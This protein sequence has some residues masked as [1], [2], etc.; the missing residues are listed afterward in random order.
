MSVILFYLY[1]YDIKA[2][3]KLRDYSVQTPHIIDGWESRFSAS[4]TLVI[5]SFFKLWS[6]YSW[7]NLALI[8][9]LFFFLRWSLPLFPRLE[10]GG[11]ILAHCNLCLPGSSD[12]PASPSQ[13]A[14]TTGACHQAQLIFC[15]FSRDGF[16]H[17]GQAGLKLLYLSWSACL[18]LPKCWDYRHEPLHPVTFLF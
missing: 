12:Y 6:A 3:R 8:Y 13:V 1:P 11:T 9:G 17:V 14:G 5:I 4:F 18:G 15:I 10:C 7:F 2:R 16:Y